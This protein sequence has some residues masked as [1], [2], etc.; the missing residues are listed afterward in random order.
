MILQRYHH[1]SR[2]D[3]H[4]IYS[5][6]KTFVKGSGKWGLAGIVEIPQRQRNFIFLVT[7]GSKEGDHE[8]EEGVTK[9]G[10]LTWQSQPQ[11]R[12]RHTQIQK[13]INHNE[14][15]NNIHL[16]L[17]TD[18]NRNYTYLGLL[19]YLRHDPE[20]ESPVYFQWQIL[21][22]EIN[23]GI[24]DDIGLVL[25]NFEDT[26]A[27]QETLAQD[28]ITE[29]IVI[30]PQMD[31]VNEKVIK[32]TQEFKARKS[33]DYLEKEK[34]NRKLGLRGEELVIQFERDRL[35]DLGLNHLVDKVEHTSQLVGDGV[36]YDIKSFDENGNEIYIEVKTTKGGKT[37]GFFI[38]PNEI[39]FSRMMRDQYY[40]YRICNYSY[41]TNTGICMIFNG[42]IE[43]YVHLRPTEFK[44]V[45][46][47]I[48][49]Q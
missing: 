26:N 25:E 36:G 21:D 16:M 30:K 20:R 47:Q 12:L 33:P 40:L 32:N 9:D 35:N 48:I 7:F 28:K 6:D 37:T 42:S 17:R 31:F 23:Q 15:E 38:S 24:F 46:K 29:V 5:K 11:Q 14:D 41:E 44:A 1:Y 34:K 3:L 2:E 8:F 45:I 10:V 13:F 49:W 4:N 39:K 22:W 43:D 18:R 27:I 19:K